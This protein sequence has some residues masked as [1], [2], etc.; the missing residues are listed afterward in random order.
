MH[1]HRLE[2]DMNEVDEALKDLPAYEF[3]GNRPPRRSKQPPAPPVGETDWDAKP[4]ILKRRGEDTE[5]FT[6]GALAAALGVRP[7]TVRSWED[8]GWLPTSRFRTPAPDKHPVDGKTP[9]GRRLYTR[10]QI[11]AVVSAAIALGVVGPN[12]QRRP[13]WA[14]FT[15]SVVDAW[16]SAR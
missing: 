13:A 1:A 7:V 11:E 6:I 8:K 15:K 2:N 9:M 16:A 14:K 12:K 4:V 10:E 3:P 5:F